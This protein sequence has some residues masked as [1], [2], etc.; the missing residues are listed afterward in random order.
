MLLEVKSCVESVFHRY[1]VFPGPKGGSYNKSAFLRSYCARAQNSQ[2]FFIP[3][4]TDV[5]VPLA[6]T[7]HVI[8]Q[9]AVISQVFL[10][11]KSLP[12]LGRGENEH[13][14]HHVH[15]F[16]QVR[17]NHQIRVVRHANLI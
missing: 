6:A 14:N 10:C 9:V 7:T 17:E 13:K 15:L 4:D 8:W 11:M 5:C 12:Q 2:V 16:V 3:H 1:K